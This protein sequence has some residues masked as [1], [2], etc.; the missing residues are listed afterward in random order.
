MKL[1][2]FDQLDSSITELTQEYCQ[3]QRQVVYL[4]QRESSLLATNRTLHQQLNMAQDKI[5]Q[6]IARLQSIEGQK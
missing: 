6:V 3:L 4:Q 2:D 1:M 5:Q